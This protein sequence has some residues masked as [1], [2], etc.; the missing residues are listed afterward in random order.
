MW[1]ISQFHHAGWHL[2]F[3]NLRARHAIFFEAEI[4]AGYEF[5]CAASIIPAAIN[6]LEN[7]QSSSWNNERAIEQPGTYV[8]NLFDEERQH[9]YV[10]RRYLFGG[11]N[12]ENQ[13][14]CHWSGARWPLPVLGAHY[15]CVFNKHAASSQRGIPA[16][17]LQ[18]NTFICSL[19]IAPRRGRISL[20]S[21]CITVV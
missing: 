4:I 19:Q 6:N 7:N 21:L 11:R 20:L 5:L 8:F 10:T 12:A 18:R 17:R 1:F 14:L 2:V 13:Y 16:P 9:S 15:T 3:S